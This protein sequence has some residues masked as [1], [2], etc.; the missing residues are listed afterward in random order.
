MGIDLHRPYERY[1]SAL[2]GARQ[3]GEPI[4][5]PAAL[6][7]LDVLDRNI[8]RLLEPARKAGKT[9]RLATKSVRCPALIRYILERSAGAIRGLMSYS[10]QE[11]VFLCDVGSE[12]ILV[13]YPS[14]QPSDCEL[15]AEL[16]GAGERVSVVV[17]CPEHTDSL[18]AAARKF[19]SRIPVV[20]EADV[21]LRLLGGRIQ[22]GARRSPLRTAEGLV[23]LAESLR[24][25]PHLR[26]LG[27]MAYESQIAGVGEVNPHSRWLNPVRSWMKRA[28][29]P[30]VRLRRREIREELD[31]K[32]LLVGLFNGGGTGSLRESCQDAA[33]TEVTVGSGFL[34]GHLFDHF[35]RLR[36]EPAL[37][38][39]LSVARRPGPRWVTCHGGGYVAS[40]P[41]GRDRLPEPWL[42]QGLRYAA[43][44]GAGE[45]Q[46][47]LRVPPGIDLGPG[48]C[49]FF[50]HAKSGELAEHFNEYLFLRGDRIES[51]A[52]TY[53]G[54]GKAFL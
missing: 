46:T 2:F 33:L 6:V 41:P 31:E 52:P 17:D 36:L 14:A 44:E 16:N 21:S 40:G 47:P 26:F 49:V 50:R 13:A 8:D 23:E 24:Q 39:A 19:G 34:C 18:E 1:C 42:P 4:R 10:V 20:I 43:L 29:R 48:D 11:A 28:S 22:L 27:V 37:F 5:L 25:R 15:L 30:L 32:G 53:R 3:A 12:D 38:F 54:L 45:V 7:D 51:R 35:P 9:I